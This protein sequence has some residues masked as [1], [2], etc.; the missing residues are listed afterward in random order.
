MRITKTAEYAL[1]ICLDLARNKNGLLSLKKITAKHRLSYGFGRK[2]AR[3][4]MVHGLI[5][6]EEGKEGGYQLNKPPHEIKLY[7][8]LD[9]VEGRVVKVRKHSTSILEKLQEAIDETYNNINLG[10]LAKGEIPC[11]KMWR[12]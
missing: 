6:G 3:L 10:V 8:I 5:D 4:L 9:A 7:H 11:A 2:I 12:K 1:I